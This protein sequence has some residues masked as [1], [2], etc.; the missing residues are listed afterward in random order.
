MEVRSLLPTERMEEVDSRSAVTDVG[1]GGE[2]HVKF[3]VDE[4]S[5]REDL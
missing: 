4:V 2:R 5:P 3:W 1:I